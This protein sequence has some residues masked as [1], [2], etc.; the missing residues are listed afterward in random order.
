M[1]LEGHALAE[2][3]EPVFEKQEQVNNYKGNGIKWLFVGAMEV[4]EK[5]KERLG[6]M[7]EQLKAKQKS[8][9]ASLAGYS[10]TGA[11]PIVGG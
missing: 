8:Q 10:G 4:L 2:V 1:P 11:Y 9:R 3:M 5:D 6:V 7:N